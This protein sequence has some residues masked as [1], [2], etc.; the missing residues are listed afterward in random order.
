MYLRVETIT[1]KKLA[2]KSKKMSFAHNTTKELWQGFMPQRKDIKDNVS[3]DLFSV[4]VYNNPLFFTH[5][6]PSAEFTKWAAIE[7][8]G[9]THIPVGIETLILPTGL[10]AVFLHKGPVSNGPKTYEYIFRTWLPNSEYILDNRP[11]FALMGEKYK[12]NEPDSEEEIW[13]PVKRKG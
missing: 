12:N 13:I 2:G 11:H 9:F 3:T 6:N 10:Y 4:E 5:F 7:V 1:E 8:T